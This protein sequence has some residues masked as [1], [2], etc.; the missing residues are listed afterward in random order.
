MPVCGECGQENPEGARFCNACAAPLTA[1]HAMAREKC[2]VV[3][4]FFAVPFAVV[5]TTLGRSRELD[6]LARSAT[7]STRWLDAGATTYIREAE[8]LFAASA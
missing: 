8:S 4:I 6:A 5:L 1:E 7:I 3:T 2:K